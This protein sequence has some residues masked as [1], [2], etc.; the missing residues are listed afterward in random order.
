MV[1]GSVVS[2]YDN[3]R[4]YGLSYQTTV[5]G[6]YTC[7]VTCETGC[8]AEDYGTVTI[9]EGPTADA[10]SDQEIAAGGSVEIG[11]TPTGSGGVGTLTYS[12]TPTTDL[13]DS[14]IANP[15]ASPGDDTTYTVTVTDENGC[16]DSDSMTVTVPVVG[17]GGPPS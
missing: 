3:R 17:G 7:K 15:T 16:Q 13:S 4:R 8:S 6:D 9:L 2:G 1:S 11:G 10:G 12:W 5:A 14:N